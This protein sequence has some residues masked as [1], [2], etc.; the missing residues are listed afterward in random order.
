MDDF[1]RQRQVLLSALRVAK[2]EKGPGWYQHC[3]SIVQQL[4]KLDDP[5]SEH[6][7]CGNE[8]LNRSA[9]NSRVF[10]RQDFP[11]SVESECK[12]IRTATIPPSEVDLKLKREKER[13]RAREKYYRK[14]AEREQLEFDECEKERQRRNRSIAKPFPYCPDRIINGDDVP[15]HGEAAQKYHF[16]IPDP[17]QPQIPKKMTIEEATGL[18]NGEF[19]KKFFP[20]LIVK[21]QQ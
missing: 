9:T 2:G 16:V 14:K 12:I 6:V 11:G 4:S 18:T 5:F 15:M 17:F 21:P 10:G 8:M 13:Q 20:H 3:R 1:E 19:M 7:Y